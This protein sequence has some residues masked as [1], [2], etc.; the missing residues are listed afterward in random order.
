MDF[1]KDQNPRPV[2]LADQLVG[3][4]EYVKTAN[5][6]VVEDLKGLQDIA[7]ADPAAREYPVHTKAATWLSAAYCLGTDSDEKKMGIIKAAADTWG[8]S[9]DIDALEIALASHVKAASE[10]VSRYALTV[11]FGEHGPG[12]TRNFYPINDP[13]EI[14]VAAR[15]MTKGAADRTLPLE[16][17]RAGSIELVK[18]AR[19]MHMDMNDIHPRVLAIGEERL[20][21]FDNALEI[22]ELRKHAGVD[23][24]GLE[25]Y[26]LAAL[27]AQNEPQEIDKWLDLWLDL[28]H[29]YQVKYSSV[30]LPDPFVA[31]FAGESLAVIDKMATE[32]VLVGD[33]MIPKTV[34]A[35]VPSVRIEQHFSKSACVSIQEAQGV[36]SAT[37][38]LAT[39]KL[40][41]L[42]PSETKTLLEVLLKS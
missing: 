9:E 24:E 16:Y 8:I 39:D 41:S 15:N 25:L 11:D 13:S 33:V 4:P 29:T 30:L 19:E 31:F 20:P 22:A 21:D 32:M 42:S 3:L 7:F 26:K 35:G 17:F 34:F 40:A 37:P 36:A 18:A 28:D 14:A 6:L 23:T 12:G 1:V 27:G 2:Y 38:H 5:T 10:P